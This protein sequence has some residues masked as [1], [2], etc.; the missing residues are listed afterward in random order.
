MHSES[1]VNV[2]ADELRPHVIEAAPEFC[3]TLDRYV[4]TLA[5]ATPRRTAALLR[6]YR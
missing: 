3:G 2:K 1:L 5:L 4:R 6:S